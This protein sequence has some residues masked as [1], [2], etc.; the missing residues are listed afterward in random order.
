MIEIRPEPSLKPAVLAKTRS[1]IGRAYDRLITGLA[2][3]SAV[4][5]VL[6]MIGVGVDVAARSL[7]GRPIGW[8]FESIENALL[9]IPFLGMAW[10][11]RRGEHVIVDVVVENTPPAVRRVLKVLASTVAALTCAT[12]A[13][14]ALGA[15]WDNYDR[16]VLT[17]GIYPIPK[18]PFVALIA[19]G[20]ALTAIEFT[21][22]TFA[23]WRGPADAPAGS[24]EV[25]S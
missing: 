17:V 16:G 6:V 22:E 8:M 11:V 23:D 2:M 4:L 13:F 18:Y 7:L 3:L 21:R 12:I 5:I 9:C 24:D 14:W 10:L 19:V 1:V 15:A 20:F 25:K